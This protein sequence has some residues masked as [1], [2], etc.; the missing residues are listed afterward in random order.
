MK[1]QKAIEPERDCQFIRIGP[2]KEDFGFV[3]TIN[4]KFRRIK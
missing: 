4:D 1:I 2:D 3:K